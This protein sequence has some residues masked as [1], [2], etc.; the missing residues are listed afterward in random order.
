MVVARDQLLSLQWDQAYKSFNAIVTELDGRNG[1]C[2]VNDSGS[3]AKLTYRFFTSPV[4]DC[5]TILLMT[6]L[7]SPVFYLLCRRRNS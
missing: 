1:Q 7:K 3:P 2:N 6:D 5:C 4:V